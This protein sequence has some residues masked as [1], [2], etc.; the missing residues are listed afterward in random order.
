MEVLAQNRLKFSGSRTDHRTVKLGSGAVP[1][2]CRV[3]R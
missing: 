3:C 1:K 2:F